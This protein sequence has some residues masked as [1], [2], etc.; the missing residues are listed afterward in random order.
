MLGQAQTPPCLLTL[1]AG[2]AVLSALQFSAVVRGLGEKETARNYGTQLGVW[3][4][5]IPAVV[6]LASIAQQIRVGRRSGIKQLAED[7][8]ALAP[9][10]PKVWRTSSRGNERLRLLGGCHQGP[11]TPGPL[12]HAARHILQVGVATLAQGVVGGP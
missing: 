6:G 9:G 10:S 5:F 4:N 3:L 12:A 8:Q 11:A 2:V 7:Q 1:G